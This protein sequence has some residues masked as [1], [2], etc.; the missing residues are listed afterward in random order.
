MGDDRHFQQTSLFSGNLQKVKAPLTSLLLH[1]QR[2]L[3]GS[4]KL[5]NLIAG[6]TEMRGPGLFISM[7]YTD[8]VETENTIHYNVL[9]VGNF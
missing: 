8:A 5:R 6:I 3:D 2:A 9:L 1:P 7:I 4:N